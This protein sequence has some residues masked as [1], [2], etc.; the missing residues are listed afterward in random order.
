MASQCTSARRCK[1]CG[2]QHHTLLCEKAPTPNDQS[3]Q[4]NSSVASF[5]PMQDKINTGWLNDESSSAF[6]VIE[7]Q[8]YSSVLNTSESYESWNESET[9]ADL[10]NL[11]V[12]TSLKQDVEQSYTLIIRMYGYSTIF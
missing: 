11:H 10:S 4:L 1:N 2:Q 8:N 12:S 6:E 3:N 9:D 7:T 5:V